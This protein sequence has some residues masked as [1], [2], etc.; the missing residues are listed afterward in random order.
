MAGVFLA[1]LTRG[2]NFSLLLN[3]CI[4]TELEPKHRSLSQPGGGS[5]SVPSS[6]GPAAA[7]VPPHIS[8]LLLRENPR[9]FN[10]PA[11]VGST[12]L[13]SPDLGGRDDRGALPAQSGTQR[14]MGMQRDTG[15]ARSSPCPAHQE[16]HRPSRQ[17]QED[18]LWFW[19]ERFPRA[20]RLKPCRNALVQRRAS[21]QRAPFVGTRSSEQDSCSKGFE[22]AQK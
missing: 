18:L 9:G 16:A 17:I 2:C 12:S 10:P 5:S 4:V 13:E 21:R 20:L 8:S 7:A 11:T 19:Q 14:V 3:P 6:G 1:A 22:G 15:M